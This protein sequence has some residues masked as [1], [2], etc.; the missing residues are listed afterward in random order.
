MSEEVRFPYNR[1]RTRK[2]KKNFI[3][4]EILGRYNIWSFQLSERDICGSILYGLFFYTL[5]E[6]VLICSNILSFP[7]EVPSFL[8]SVD[9]HL[10]NLYPLRRDGSHSL[11]MILG[12]LRCRQPTYVPYSLLSGGSRVL[13]TFQS[14]LWGYRSVETG[15]FPLDRNFSNWSLWVGDGVLLPFFEQGCPRNSSFV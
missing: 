3:I 5:W 13:S 1:E 6:K 10:L 9:F 4:P 7:L 8:F 15:S 14:L 11:P 12:A 2:K